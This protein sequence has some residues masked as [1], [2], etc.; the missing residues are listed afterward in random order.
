MRT[1]HAKAS[2]PATA[3][4]THGSS[5][6][7][8]KFASCQCGPHISKVSTPQQ[9]LQNFNTTTKESSKRVDLRAP[10]FC[11]STSHELQDAKTEVTTRLQCGETLDTAAAIIGE[12]RNTIPGLNVAHGTGTLRA[13]SQAQMSGVGC[14]P[15]KHHETQAPTELKPKGLQD[16]PSLHPPALSYARLTRA[17][18]VSPNPRADLNHLRQHTK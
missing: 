15:I 18:N 17:T 14:V 11:K 2:R 8:I 16:L 3:A 6:W 9:N 5:S 7:S 4:R 1:F 10:H 12:G 13:G